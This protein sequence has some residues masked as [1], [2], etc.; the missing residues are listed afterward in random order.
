[1]T[2]THI[3]DPLLNDAELQRLRTLIMNQQSTHPMVNSLTTGPHRSYQ[4]GQGMER[5][6][7]R[8]Y[9][10]GDDI[11]HMD[12]RATA[13]SAKPITKV[14]VAERQKQALMVVDRRNSMYFGTR[15]EIK[16]VTAARVAAIL[17]FSA[18]S[19]HTAMA[20]LVINSDDVQ[21]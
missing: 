5:L 9:Q 4:H 12:W 10:S 8:A 1:M 7:V 3:N 15:Q 2:A 18:M 16:A 20:G 6:D 17:C 13:R 19:D 14:F 21:Y 11:R